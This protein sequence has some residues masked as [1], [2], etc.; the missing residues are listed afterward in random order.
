MVKSK[1]RR[2]ASEDKSDGGQ[3]MKTEKDHQI[4]EEVNHLMEVLGQ[5]G[6]PTEALKELLADN[7]KISSTGL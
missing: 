3:N 2:E 7:T 4:D 6:D 5:K 1:D